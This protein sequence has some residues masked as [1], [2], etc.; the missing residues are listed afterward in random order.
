MDSRFT[1][2]Y[3]DGH[4]PT[5]KTMPFTEVLNPDKTFKSQEELVQAFKA[6]GVNNPQN[7]KIVFT[8]QRGI[9][10]CI[11]EAATAILGNENAKVYDG[12]WEEYS[13]KIRG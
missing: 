12:S 5:S 4:I 2:I 8:C 10:A 9:T 13:R 3:D 6:Q 11:L 7:E 1:K